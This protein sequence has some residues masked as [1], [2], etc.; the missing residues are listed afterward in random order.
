MCACVGGVRAPSMPHRS[1]QNKKNC[2]NPKRLSGLGGERYS[3]NPR[4]AVS[5]VWTE[6]K[7]PQEAATTRGKNRDSAKVITGDDYREG[8]SQQIC[9]LT[10]FFFFFLNFLTDLLGLPAV[11]K[12]SQ[13][14]PEHFFICM[15]H[16]GLRF[17]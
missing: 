4:N 17:S 9:Q 7:K 15:K 6:K 12:M 10:G 8:W 11:Q 1:L 14:S 3:T 13:S 16:G 2:K 5:A